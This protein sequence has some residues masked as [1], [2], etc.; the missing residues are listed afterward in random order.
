M[1]LNDFTET[2]KEILELA[3]ENVGYLFTL[4]VILKQSELSE[5]EAQK[6]LNSLF[7]KGIVSKK[8]ENKELMDTNL[9]FKYGL[10]ENKFVDMEKVEN[11]YWEDYQDFIRGTVCP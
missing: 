10:R 11:Q 6:A 8:E 3:V 4:K 9:K 1:N 5:E 2:E 7:S